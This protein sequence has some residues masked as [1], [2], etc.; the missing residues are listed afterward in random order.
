MLEPVPGEVKSEVP[1]AIAQQR[2]PP[3]GRRRSTPHDGGEGIDEVGAG[4]RHRDVETPVDRG[5]QDSPRCTGKGMKLM[6]TP[7]PNAAVIEWRFRLHRCESVSRSPKRLKYHLWR[8]S[9]ISCENFLI[10][11]L[12]IDSN[13]SSWRVAPRHEPEMVKPHCNQDALVSCRRVI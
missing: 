2:P 10:N 7:T 6:A 8:R 11:L 3:R 4:D 9:W 13:S 12:G 5:E 1:R